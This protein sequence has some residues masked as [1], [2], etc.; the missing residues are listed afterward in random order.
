MPELRWV[1]KSW[2]EDG[3]PFATEWYKAESEYGYL[4]IEARPPYCDRGRWVA[5]IF[6]NDWPS[7]WY[8]DASG[9]WP[10]YYFD[11]ERAQAELQAWADFRLLHSVRR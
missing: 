8:D 9:G 1:R 2:G 5:K 6:G 7:P 4:T 10:R 11:L 3:K